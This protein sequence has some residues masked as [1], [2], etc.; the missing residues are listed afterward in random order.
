MYTHTTRATLRL[1]SLCKVAGHTFS[2]SPTCRHTQE[3]LCMHKDMTACY[4]RSPPIRERAEW[5]RF[6]GSLLPSHTVGAQRTLAEQQAHTST[7]HSCMNADRY[8]PKLHTSNTTHMFTHTHH[9]THT[10]SNNTQT[11]TSLIPMGTCTFK[12]VHMCPLAAEHAHTLTHHGRL[13]G[14]RHT[15]LAVIHTWPSSAHIRCGR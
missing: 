3:H 15:A 14:P 11:P 5:V 7:H 12:H 1:V 6:T 2:T 9:S 8:A 10:T 4:H 13:P